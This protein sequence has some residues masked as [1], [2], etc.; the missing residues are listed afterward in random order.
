M[1]SVKVHK[2]SGKKKEKNKRE[3]NLEEELNIRYHDFNPEWNY[4]ISPRKRHGKK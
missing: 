3:D 1:N 4:T 2:Q